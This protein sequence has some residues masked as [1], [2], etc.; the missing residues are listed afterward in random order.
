MLRRRA[1]PAA[2]LLVLLSWEGHSLRLPSAPKSAAGTLILVRH[3]TT[4]HDDAYTFTGWS[5]PDIN[6]HGEQQV[7]EAARRVK[8]AGY[9]FDVAYTSMLKRSIHTTWLLLGSLEKTYVE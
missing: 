3:G 6:T 2:L 5:D 8:E 7:E 4:P 9:S 1:R